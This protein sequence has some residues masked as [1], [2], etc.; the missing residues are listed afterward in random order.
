MN[1]NTPDFKE[2]GRAW[3]YCDQHQRAHMTGW[4]TV[5]V[6]NKVCLCDGD[7]TEDEAT[8]KCRRWGFKM[9]YDNT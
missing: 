6:S 8:E 4:C 7:K 9:R 1:E 2:W 5:G 3:V